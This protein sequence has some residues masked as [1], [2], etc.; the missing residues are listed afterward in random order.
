MSAPRTVDEVNHLEQTLREQWLALRT[1]VG[2]LDA[3][4]VAMPSVLDGWTVAELVAHLGRA[5]D[6]LAAAQPTPPGTVPL[7][8][9]EYVGGYPGRA[10]AIADITR[11]LAVEIADDPLAAVDR[12]VE[13]AFA[14]LGVLRDLGVD[15]VVQARRAPILLSE[16]ILSRLIELVVHADD[17]LRSTSGAPV[18]TGGAPGPLV[19]AAVTLVSDTLLEI[20]VDRGGWQVEVVDELGWIR[21]ACG[22]VPH[23]MENLAAALRPAHTAGGL[24]DLGNMLPLL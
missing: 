22:R 21:L 6:A 17:L 18:L 7:T 9:G 2:R 20:A 13:G 23:T 15:P 10:Q 4:A 24:P 3:D 11:E 19:P 8:L 14:Q 1:W 5:M 12:M 16:M